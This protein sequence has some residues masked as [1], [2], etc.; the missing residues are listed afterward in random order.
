MKLN[1]NNNNNNNTDAILNLYNLFKNKKI[2]FALPVP[3]SETKERK[4]SWCFKT[5][6]LLEGRCPTESFSFQS[7]GH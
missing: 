7:L 1:N 2:D 5:C 3:G 6:C 4:L